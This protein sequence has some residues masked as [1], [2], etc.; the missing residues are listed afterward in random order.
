MAGTNLKFVDTS[1]T[2]DYQRLRIN[3]IATDIHAAYTGTAALSVTSIT[4]GG[5]PVTGG[6]SSTDNLPEGSSNLYFTS[7]RVDDRVNTLVTAGTA[8][9]KV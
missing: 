1:N 8:I 2:V 9:T 7:E 5:N 6:I 3:E 4:I